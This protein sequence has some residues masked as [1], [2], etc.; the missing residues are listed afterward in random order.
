[1]VGDQ[2]AD[3]AL[4]Q[5]TDDLLDIEHGDRV[6]AGE[7]FVEQDETRTGGE[8]ARDFDAAALAAGERQC[9]VTAQM[10]DMQL[11]QQAFQALVDFRLGQVLQ[12]EHRAA[13][14]P[15]PSAS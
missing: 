7:R 1:M 12:F 15:A 13:R 2:H 10:R 9:R 4:L 14:S 8:R 6:D 5:E 11:A 3:A